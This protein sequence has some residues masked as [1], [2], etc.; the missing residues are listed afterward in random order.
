MKMG[1]FAVVGREIEGGRRF[2]H[3][4]SGR[5]HHHAEVWRDNAGMD[6]VF[7]YTIADY[8]GQVFR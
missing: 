5:F 2:L 7:V 8:M 4:L 1:L 6:V 3:R